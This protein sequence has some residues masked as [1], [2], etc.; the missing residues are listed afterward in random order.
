M[1]EGFFMTGVGSMLISL[2]VKV[3]DRWWLLLKHQ[4]FCYKSEWG[5]SFPLLAMLIT[6]GL[7]QIFS[8]VL[9]TIAFCG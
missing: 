7:S 5:E 2:V 4:D 1:L 6:R 8:S 3:S 9:N